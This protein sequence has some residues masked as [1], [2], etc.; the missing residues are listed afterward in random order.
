MASLNG[1]VGRL[2]PEDEQRMGSVPGHRQTGL[3]RVEQT[4]VG[5]VEPGL[6]DL[7]D[8]LCP[9]GKLANRTPAEARWEGL[10]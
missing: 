7:A 6:G 5:G 8:A 10:R 2:E 3:P 9:F 1:M 4:A